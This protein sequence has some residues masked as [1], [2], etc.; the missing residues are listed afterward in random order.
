MHIDLYT[1]KTI[2]TFIA[3][4]LAMFALKPILQTQAAMAQGAYAG[5]PFS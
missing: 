4:L 2:V 5:I 3:L 1:K